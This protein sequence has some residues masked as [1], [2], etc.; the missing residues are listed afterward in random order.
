MG[1]QCDINKLISDFGF[2]EPVIIDGI[3]DDDKYRLCQKNKKG[4]LFIAKEVN[5]KKGESWDFTEWWNEEIKYVFS[6]RI[7][8]WAYG[9]VCGFPPYEE[10]LKH[11]TQAIKSIAFINI[12]KKSGGGGAADRDRIISLSMH[13]SISLNLI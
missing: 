6:H 11:K 5:A 13:K 1:R 8:T 3:I 2:T 4:I 12:N 10:A 7:A 9:L